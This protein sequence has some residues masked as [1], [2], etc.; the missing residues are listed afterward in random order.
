MTAKIEA[1]HQQFLTGAS[2]PVRVL[3]EIAS[4]AARVQTL[5]NAFIWTNWEKARQTAEQSWRRFRQGRSLNVLDGIPVG[6]KD[7]FETEGVPTTAGSKILR[8]YRPERDGAVVALL[9]QHGA[10]L[11]V[12]KLNLHEFAFGPTGTS[13]YF[14]AVKNP[15]DPR[16]M[17][18]GSSS[19]SAA[20]VAAGLL[21]AALGTDTGGSIRIPAA[22]CGVCGLKPTYDRISREGVIPLSWTLDHVGPL[23]AGVEDLAIMLDGMTGAK[24]LDARSGLNTPR[25]TWRLFWPE[26]P[27]WQCLDSELQ[28]RFDSR[29]EALATQ[30][31]V[32]ITITRGPLP[33]IERIRAAQLVIIGAESANYHWQ[34]LKEQPQN[35]QPDVRERLMARSTYLAMQYIEAMR[36]R[37]RLMEAYHAWFDTQG[38]D[39]IILPTVPMFPPELET[40][41]RPGF[42]GGMEDI[43]NLAVWFTSPFNLLGL[44]A[45]TIP[46]DVAHSGFSVNAQIVGDHGQDI[47]VLQLAHVWETLAGA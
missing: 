24:G 31:P 42:N 40:T 25:A 8:D 38:Y 11:D 1:L 3:E 47:K 44:P 35:Y 20:V 21:P 46:V 34:W 29:V 14:G 18:G 32:P 19:G 15:V 6:L 17:A 10:N 5:T 45:V 12:G 33:E 28:R 7:L 13:S 16:F 36:E 41:E 2:D 4:Q 30:C 39:A 37:T 43:R 26:G 22:F 9:R 27:S 23:A